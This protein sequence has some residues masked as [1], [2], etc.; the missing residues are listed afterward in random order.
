MESSNSESAEG[1]V[2]IICG[3]GS[4]PFSVAEAVTRRGRSVVLFALRGFADP[5]GVA[6][7]RHYWMA[8]GQYGWFMRMAAKEGCQ[9]IVFIGS[10]VRPS[11]W[12]IRFDLATLMRL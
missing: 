12:Q 9:D 3:G 5:V 11:L 4:L 10:V 2:G 1:P 8:L 6:N 7:Y